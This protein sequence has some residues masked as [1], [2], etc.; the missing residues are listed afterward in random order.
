VTSLRELPMDIAPGRDLWPEIEARLG[1]ERGAGPSRFGSKP[2]LHLLALAAVISAVAV[3]V[4]LGRNVLPGANQPAPST[5]QANPDT[6]SD[7]T[8]SSSALGGANVLPAAYV[9]Q[10]AA[11][12]ASFDQQVRALPPKSR[13][14]VLASLAAIR[15]SMNDIQE[16]LGREPGNALLQELLVNTYQD[17]MRV[18]TVVHE[19]GDARKEI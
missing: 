2:Q 3:G 16:A 1:A 19:A 10:R 13:D 6:G 7:A 5:A 11:L 17:E 4:W 8:Q 18:L 14:K 9:K 12:L 15:K